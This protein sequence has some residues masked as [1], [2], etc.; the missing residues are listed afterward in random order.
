MA[1]TN[2][3]L[4]EALKVHMG[5]EGARLIAELFPAARDLATKDDIAHLERVTKDDIARLERATKDDIARLEMATKDEIG[6]LERL[7][8]GLDG[9]FAELEAKFLRWTL[10]FF[11]PLWITILAAL[12]T[13]AIK[14]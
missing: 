10:T 11:V 13:V 2:L 7:I 9:R 12:V 8:G 4:Y 1:A 6:R 14:S 3:E 5:E